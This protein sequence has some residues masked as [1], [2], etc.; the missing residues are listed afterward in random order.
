[1]TRLRWGL[2]ALAVLVIA[3]Q[4]RAATFN[5]N[6]YY[7]RFSGTPNVT[8]LPF[9]YDDSGAGT[10]TYGTQNNIASLNGADGIMFAPNGNLIVT[11]NSTNAVYRLDASNGNLLQTVPTGQGVADFHMALDPTGTK[12]YSSSSYGNRTVGGLDTFGIN[13]NGTFNNP[14]VTSITPTHG[15]DQNITQLAF[16]PNGKVFYTNGQPNSNGAVGLFTLGSPNQT[17]QLFAANTINAAHGII[18]DPFTGKIT[19]F[20][21]GGVATLDPTAGSDA[22]IIASLKQRNGINFDFDQGS[23][24]GFGHALIAGNGEITFIDYSATGDI[25]DPADKIFIRSIDGAGNAFGNID[26][27]APLVGL[28]SQGSTPVPPSAILLATGCMS[29][30][31]Y[32]W[33]RRKSA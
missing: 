10:L 20:G 21:G 11:S 17:D 13:A 19:M 5:G 23:V 33:R 27:V 22:A 8:S 18:Y 1:M 14:T 2:L 25:T 32:G 15:N 28:G 30:F 26:N 4:S 9:S 7:T 31:G 16:A 24:D 29:L 3:G 12:F 6:L